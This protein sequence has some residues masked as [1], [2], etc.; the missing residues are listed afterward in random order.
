MVEVSIMRELSNIEAEQGLLGALLVDNSAFDRVSEILKSDFF[1]QAVHGRI[2]GKICAFVQDN[3][4]ASPITLKNYFESDPDLQENGGAG[5]LADL[6]ANSLGAFNVHDYAATITDLHYRRQM[7]N[8]AE[9]IAAIAKNSERKDLISETE[10]ILTEVST[11]SQTNELTVQDAL[12]QAEKWIYDIADG[13]IKPIKTGYQAIDRVI[14][15]LFGS[16]LYIIAARP[17][18]GK[19]TLALNIADNIAKH[20]P[21]L[22]LSLEMSGQELA[23]RLIASR[24]SLCM[25][26]QQSPHNLNMVEREELSNARQQIS[27]EIKLII[28]DTGGATVHQIKSFIRRFVRVYG[29]GP[30]FVDY[31]GLIKTDKRISQ[32]V[33]QIEEI[34]NELKAIAKQFDVPV[35]L[36]SQLNRGLEARDDKRPITADL[37]DSGAI[38]QDADCIMFVYREEEYIKRDE[39][40]QKSG[41]GDE[42]FNA[43]YADWGDLMHRVRGEAEV[44]VAKNRQGNN[45]TVKLKFNGEKQRFYDHD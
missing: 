18:M 11:R 27:D 31:L 8:A 3:K 5:Y 2:Y 28:N 10:R 34:T 14:G 26:R 43:R 16:R 45:G 13:K 4:Q 36:L 35:V 32:K 25:Q 12:A 41:E 9:S 38:E 7:I 39:P 44:I 22:F 42:K 17:G 24:T 19:T 29:K 6:A 21:A 1:F 37:R 33:H 40:K 30:I 20:T 15:G 23:M